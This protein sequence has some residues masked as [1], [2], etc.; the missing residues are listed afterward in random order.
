MLLKVESQKDLQLSVLSPERS[1][2]ATHYLSAFAFGLNFLI[3]SKL[4][5]IALNYLKFQQHPSSQQL[6]L[7][8]SFHGK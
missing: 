5:K 8:F 1:S 7:A 6:G 2:D 3:T 4:E